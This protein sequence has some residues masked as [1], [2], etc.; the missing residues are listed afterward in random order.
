[1]VLDVNVRRVALDVVTRVAFEGRRFSEAFE[2]K[3][4]GLAVDARDRS[5]LHQIAAGAVRHGNTLDGLIEMHSSRPLAEIQHPVLAALRVGAYQ[6]VYLTRVP[7]HA[8]VSET[9]EAVRAVRPSACSFTNAVLR[10]ISASIDRKISATT[11]IGRPG[12]LIPIGD[13]WCRF[14]ETVCPDQAVD[15]PGFF[16][17]CLSYP[18]DLAALFICRFGMAHS[19]QVGRILNEPAPMYL[20][21][22]VRKCSPAD[23]L[24]TLLKAGINA[25]PGG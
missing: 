18:A 9:V 19:F 21:V 25:A 6:L 15:F 24:D 3:V 8:A 23:F 5:L 14:N 7:P 17:A 22:N 2:E 11:P 20:R 1:M 10:S 4:R 12:T 13:G 16:E